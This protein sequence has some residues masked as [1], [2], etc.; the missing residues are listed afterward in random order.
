MSEPT[1]A[2]PDS[3]K[4]IFI[5]NAPTGTVYIFA[6]LPLTVLR[7]AWRTTSPDDCDRPG[8]PCIAINLHSDEELEESM[9]LCRLAMREHHEPN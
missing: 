2:S 4:P 6:F 3:E 1:P 9:E 7:K 8:E 5:L